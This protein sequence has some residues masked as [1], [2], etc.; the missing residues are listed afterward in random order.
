MSSLNDTRPLPVSVIEIASGVIEYVKSACVKCSSP[1]LKSSVMVCGGGMDE[2]YSDDRGRE[3]ADH[4]DRPFSQLRASSHSGGFCSGNDVPSTL[5]VA[6]VPP[7][8]SLEA[9]AF[10][11]AWAAPSPLDL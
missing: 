6:F 4:L 9:K 8:S 10:I 5:N 7:V 3:I 11:R 2:I 1:G